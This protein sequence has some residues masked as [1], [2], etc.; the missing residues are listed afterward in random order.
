MKITHCKV[1]HLISPL[2]YTLNKPSFSYLVENAVGKEQSQARLILAKDK[3]LKEIIYDSGFTNLNPLSTIIDISLEPCHRYFWTVTVRTDANEEATS[4]VNWFETS[5]ESQKWIGQWLSCDSTVGRHPIFSKQ[6]TL[7]KLVRKARLYVSGLGLYEVYIDDKKV[8]QEFLTPYCNNYE[9]WIQYQTY[10]VTPYISNTFSL[11]I[12]LGNG[13]YKGRYGNNTAE[14]PFEKQHTWKVIAELHLELEDG[15][16][17]IIPTDESWCVKRSNILNSSI[18]DGEILD[19]T[20]PI[21]ESEPVK[22][23]DEEMPPL[24][25]RYS[26]P[27]T[28]HQE[29]HVKQ[30]I[31]TPKGDLVLD[32]G[33]N[34]AGIFRLHVHE[35][36]GKQIRLQFAEFMEDGEF[37][38]EN[39]RSAKAEYQYTSNGESTILQPHFTFYGYR[40]VKLEG[41]TNFNPND[42]VGL[43]MYSEIADIGDITTGN[44]LVNQ[45][46]HNARWG[47]Y[48]NFID[49]P[50][51]C[52]QRDERLGWTGDAQVFSATASFYTDTYAF[53][54]KYLKDMATE[55]AKLGG[56]V[57]N[58]VPAYSDNNSCAVWGD[59]ATIIPWNLYQFY[60]DINILQDCFDSMKAWVDYMTKADQGVGKWKERFHWGDWLALDNPNGGDEQIFGGTDIGLIA[61]IYYMNSA[62]ILSKTAAV[63]G[64][65][66]LAENYKNLAENIRQRILYEYYTPSGRCA[67]ATQTAYLLT[68]KYHLSTNPEEA[69]KT[70]R[71]LFKQRNDKLATG[72]VGTSIM[73][74][75]LSDN[76]MIDL[77]YKLLLNEEYPGWLYAVKK[78]ATTIWERWN[79]ITENGKMI[80]S[81]MTSLNHYAYGSIVEWIWRYV[82]GLTQDPD[83]GEGFKKVIFQPHLNHKLGTTKATYQSAS[84]KWVSEWEILDKKNIRLH[85]EVPFGCSAKLILPYAT[86][87]VYITNNPIIKHRKGEVCYLQPGEYDITYQ[88]DSRFYGLSLN[89]HISDIVKNK[90]LYQFILQELPMFSQLP[91][92]MYDQEFQ[93]AVSMLMA[94]SGIQ[95]DDFFKKV[96]QKILELN[97]SKN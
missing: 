7:N 58:V 94:M 50:T 82:A 80:E 52:P 18:Y 8:G 31:M 40:Y 30:V 17:L 20:L 43:V 10:D 24:V 22:L 12:L 29:L 5:K 97:N 90:E 45:L 70:L 2:G 59:A 89:S 15:S 78:G 49:I 83:G 85:L 95:G 1:N 25:A 67:N 92:E 26:T 23:V 13:W 38:R 79:S 88:A 64:K 41:V 93:P 47:M 6:I 61:D 77:A 27:V 21:L 87:E 54:N 66:N 14:L 73:N 4:D 71:N 62:D 53:Y 48:S 51:D 74:P 33:Q 3:Q 96:Q 34:F 91:K 84:G 28:I 69:Q 11:N 44:S 46:I 35:P 56:G 37:Y 39:L 76:G 75:V 19:D 72:F 55:Q 65:V 32:L 36:K 16:Q 86:P 60:G 63:L 9:S 57:P 81:G 68:L 42:F